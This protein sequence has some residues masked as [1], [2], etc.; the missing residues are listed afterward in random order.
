MLSKMIKCS[1]V[2]SIKSSKF[3]SLKKILYLLDSLEIYFFGI[4]ES[5]LDV[6]AEFF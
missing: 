2:S 1:S 4:F 3:L 6:R 5:E